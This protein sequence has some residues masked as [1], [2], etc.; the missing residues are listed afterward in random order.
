MG[1]ESFRELKVWQ[2]AK[3]L[4]IEIYKI[5]TQG[6]LKTDYGLRDQIQK[7][8]VSIAS[9]IAEGYER[10]SD[11]DF[12]RFIY[13]A[14][15]SLSELLTQLEIASGVGYLEN[16]ILEV[17]TDKCNKIGSMLTRLIKYRKAD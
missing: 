9:N 2:E 3:G 4:A 11:K 13:I 1:Y 8:A 6:K 12:I 10:N 5:T 16:D 7:S 14:K 15:G 17:L